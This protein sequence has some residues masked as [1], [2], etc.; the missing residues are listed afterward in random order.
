MKFYR[1]QGCSECNY[2]GYKGRMGLHE[3]MTLSSQ[4]QEKIFKEKLSDQ[5]IEK[6]AIE[7]GMI[8]MLQDGILKAL[9]GLTTIEE[10]IKNTK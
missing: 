7:D 8:T 4:S 1:G 6:I 9:Q 2:I 10:V 5:E 3:I